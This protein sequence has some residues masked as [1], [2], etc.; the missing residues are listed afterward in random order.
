MKRAMPANIDTYDH[1][2][3]MASPAKPMAHVVN[4]DHSVTGFLTHRRMIIDRW[5]RIAV[6]RAN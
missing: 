4:P 1:D 2:Y 3:V 6:I 5:Q